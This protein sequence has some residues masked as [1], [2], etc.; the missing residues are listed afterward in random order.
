MTTPQDLALLDADRGIAMFEK[1]EVPI[2]GVVEN[3]AYFEMPD[4]SRTHPF[5]EGGGEKLASAHG[6]SVIG[7]IPLNPSIRMG[8]DQ[9]APQV[10]EEGDDGPLM[11]IAKAVA[12]CLPVES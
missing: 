11:G 6:V 4:G 5:G 2:L 3:M 10:L 12:A 1:L 9:G 8:G 7:Q